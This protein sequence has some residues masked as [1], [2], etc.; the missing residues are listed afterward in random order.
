[1]SRVR[2]AVPDAASVRA[3]IDSRMSVRAFLP[4]PVPR[5]TLESVLA[6]ARRAPSG[7]NAQPWQVYVLQGAS[8]DELVRKVCA[9]HDAVHADP[10]LA[11]E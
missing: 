7:T 6:L 5:E 10:A 4:T 11:A 3:A 1:M 8:R 9:A 2:T